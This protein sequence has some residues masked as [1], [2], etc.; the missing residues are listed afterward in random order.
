MVL[1]I[2]L[3]SFYGMTFYPGLSSAI[4]I[5]II[6]APGV[7]LAALT[8]ILYLCRP[9]RRRIRLVSLASLLVTVFFFSA[10]TYSPALFTLVFA[11]FVIGLLGA[12]SGMSY[13]GSSSV[14]LPAFYRNGLSSKQTTLRLAVILALLLVP[15]LFFYYSV[16]ASRIVFPVTD[17]FAFVAVLFIAVCASSLLAG[18]I[19]KKKTNTNTKSYVIAYLVILTVLF[20]NYFLVQPNLSLISTGTNEP[21]YGVSIGIFA[22]H[23]TY[24]QPAAA[25]GASELFYDL[26]ANQFAYLIEI[27]VVSLTAL[28]ATAVVFAIAD[29]ALGLPAVKQMTASKATKA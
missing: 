26:Y 28:L 19:S 6:L 11:A 20:L 16:T 24:G 27:I 21:S 13:D 15:R 23:P 2:T 5:V 1:G 3:Y 17:A 29:T 12:A 7:L 22:T 25:F 14:S 10:I 9:S 4:E 18:R 8:A